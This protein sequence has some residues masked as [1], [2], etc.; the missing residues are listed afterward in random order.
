MNT[1]Y[2]LYQN[3]F[4]L[5]RYRNAGKILTT[6]IT[7]EID[8]STEYKK[9]DYKIVIRA[10]LT[11]V[12]IIGKESASNKSNG[13]TKLFGSSGLIDRHTIFI[14]PT[15]SDYTSIIL[16]LQKLRSNSGKSITLSGTPVIFEQDE[17]SKYRIE[18]NNSNVLVF[19]FPTHLSFTNYRLCDKEQFTKWCELYNKKATSL[20]IVFN[21]DTCIFWKGFKH[22]DV[23]IETRNS[24]TAGEAEC[25]KRVVNNIKIRKP[26][27]KKT[28]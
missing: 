15:E 13:L 8:F 21:T 16:H 12:I 28:D 23:V 1:L 2:I 26:R 18:I 3:A 22:G 24:P 4:E 7:N 20:P 27:E 25:F 19:N 5:L 6:Q 17:A 14:V 10:E 9:N 11:Q